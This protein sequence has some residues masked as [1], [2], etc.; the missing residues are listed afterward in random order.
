VSFHS[1]LSQ[2][3]LISENIFSGLEYLLTSSHKSHAIL[4]KIN[5]AKTIDQSQIKAYL[6]EF[7]A[8]LILSSFHQDNIKSTPH[9]NIYI[10]EKIQAKKTIKDIASNIKSPKSIVLDKIQ[11]VSFWLDAKLAYVVKNIFK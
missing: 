3:V 7:I 6:I 10:I 9:H 11:V 8:G 4:G 2:R 1:T 5:I